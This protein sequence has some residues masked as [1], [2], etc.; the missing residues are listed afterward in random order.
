MANLYARSI[1]FINRLKWLSPLIGDKVKTIRY[2]VRSRSNPMLT[3]YAHYNGINFKFRYCDL[4]ALEE[5]LVYKEYGFLSDFLLNCPQPFIVDVGAHI[6]LFSLWAY[7]K[8]SNVKALMIEANPSTNSI[9]IQNIKKNLL[10]SWGILNRAAWRNEDI[11]KFSTNAR[12]SMSHKVSPKGNLNVK[13]ITFKEI[14]ELATAEKSSI[15]LMKID[16]EGAEEAFLENADKM[17]E[18]VNRI[19][20]ELHHEFCNTQNLNTMLKKRYKII[21]NITRNTSSKTLI[22]CFDQ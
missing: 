9:L 21:Q 13:G 17:L 7:S 2:L 8:N 14:V 10:D 18:K 3:E 15:D 20:I 12:Q 19:V 1:S 5:I 22:Y 16:I 4:K 11:V 6:G